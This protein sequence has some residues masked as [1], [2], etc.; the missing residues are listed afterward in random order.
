[1]RKTFRKKGVAFA[2][3]LSMLCSLGWT[4]NAHAEEADGT[5]VTESVEVATDLDAQSVDEQTGEDEFTALPVDGMDE[6]TVESNY[7]GLPQY[8][9]KTST[10]YDVL[11]WNTSTKE[12]ILQKYN[13]DFKVQSKLVIDN[14]YI[15]PKEAAETDMLLGG[16][17]EGA[18]YNFVVTGR[19][20]IN[21][22]DAVCTLRVTKFSKDWSFI[23]ACDISNQDD[24]EIYGAFQ[25]C[26]IDFAEKDG[27]LWISTG[28]TGYG[29]DGY[30]HQGKMNLIVRIS[31]MK[32]LGSAADFFHSFSQYLTVCNAQVYQCEM[33]E[34]T[35]KILVERLEEDNYTGGW[36]Y[37][38]AAGAED[39]TSVLDCWTSDAY[40]MWSYPLYAEIAGFSSSDTRDRL[41][42]AYVTKDQDVLQQNSGNEYDLEYGMWVAS[43]TTD[44]KDTTYTKLSD[45]GIFS[46]EYY[47]VKVND[48]KFV[49]LWGVQGY[50][51]VNY[52]YA[53]A[54]PVQYACVDAYGN[55]L[56]DTV[57][58]DAGLGSA[59]P[60]T[61]ENGNVVWCVEEYNEDI[62]EKELVFYTLNVDEGTIVKKN[63][64]AH[65]N[66]TYN[67]IY[68]SK[69]DHTGVTA[70]M[71]VQLDGDTSCVDYSWY[72][73]KDNGATWIQVA[74]WNGNRFINWTPKEYG[75]YILVG[76]VRKNGDNAGVISKA[77]NFSFHPAIKGICQM[78]Y[79]GQGGGYLIGVE[80]Y[81]NPGNA[82]SYEMLILDCTLLAQNK[83]AWIYTT[84]QC[85]TSGSCLWT[86]WQPQYGYYWTL[87]RVYDENGTMIDEKCYPFVNAY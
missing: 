83:P 17:Y 15:V 56:T 51:Y 74:D 28:R 62:K 23:A 61:D 50:V 10:G 57:T 26:G 49:V 71:D 77:A 86:I 43:T 65:C 2:L 44:L 68:I 64:N 66:I 4:G 81:D 5:P 36:N 24:V 58:L 55:R 8:L 84:G 42:T 41:V 3:A 85:K 31:D 67:G 78:P 22:D 33:S 25:A 19:H 38:W 47:M 7:T 76:K 53:S 60:V 73:T 39:V 75:D 34:G 48:N 13:N 45:S 30:H 6:V 14:S 52:D 9:F 72:A 54:T 37:N 20:N 82:Y 11:L 12:L 35:R 70:I 32:L 40:G 18:E 27:K 29:K 46:D 87:F 69:S 63:P 79:T 16:V 1:M 21:E 59:Q 80:S